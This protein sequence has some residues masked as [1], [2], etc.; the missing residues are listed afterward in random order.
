M[1]LAG[2]L[3][4]NKA[5]FGQVGEQLKSLASHKQ[6]GQ[7]LNEVGGA[8]QRILVE[9]EEVVDNSSSGQSWLQGIQSTVTQINHDL[10]LVRND[11]DQLSQARTI[12]NDLSEAVHQLERVSDGIQKSVMDTRMVPIGPLFGRFKRVIRDITRNN[13][14]DIQLAIRGDKTELDKRMI[15]ELGDPLIHMVRNAADHGIESPEERT[16]AGKQGQGTVTLDA[17]HRGNKIFVQVKD[18]GKGLDPEKLKNKAIEKGI[19]TAQDAER[20]SKQQALQ[21]IW[22]PGFSTAEKVTDISGRGMGMD[23]VRSKIEQL[24]GAVELDS[25]L[26]KGT[27]ITINLP[28]TMAILP[29]LLTVISDDVFAVPMESV[30]EI[31]SVSE[32]EL[33]TVHGLETA[34]VRGRVISIVELSSLLKWNTPRS[35]W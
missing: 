28:L 6:S 21:L 4:I 9:A 29:S 22:E 1:N 24:H 12:V 13:G 30:S 17:F 32:S 2:Q 19:I 25:E 7:R 34:R 35:I 3:V 27:T 8:L 31:V 20:L 18:D 11:I 23:I 33:S 14:K 5:R 10:E 16:K 26:G 15:D